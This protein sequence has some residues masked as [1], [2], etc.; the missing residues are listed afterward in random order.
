MPTPFL[1][2]TYAVELLSHRDLTAAL[3]EK[4]QP[5]TGAFLL[6]NTAADIQTLTHASRISTHFYRIRDA[7]PCWGWEMMLTEYPH[8]TNPHHMDIEKAAFISGYLVHLLWD[9]IWTREIFTPYYTTK[10]SGTG[11]G[12]T[13]SNRIIRDHGGSLRAEN[14]RPHGARFIISLKLNV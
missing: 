7:Q 4:L 6:G 1:H 11:L 5:A 8:L 2:L 9:E 10:Q 13:I 12:L 3:C 14:I